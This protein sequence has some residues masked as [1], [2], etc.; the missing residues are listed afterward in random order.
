VPEETRSLDE[1][2]KA[3]LAQGGKLVLYAGGDAPTQQN[4]NK[5]SFEARF[6]NMTMDVIVD[7]SKFHDARVDL[8]LA[9][10]SLIPDV[11][12]IQSIQNFPRWKEQGVLM[13]YKP[14]GWS[15]VRIMA[16]FNAVE[17]LDT[18]KANRAKYY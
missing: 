4:G 2:Y 12:Q 17:Q 8:Q 6:P 13:Q 1:I 10:K 16:F 9:N 3:A 14:K 5:A 11:V 15:K 18:T 7:Y